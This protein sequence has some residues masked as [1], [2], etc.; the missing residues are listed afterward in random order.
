MPMICANCG[1]KTIFTQVIYGYERYSETQIL[2]ENGDV[3]DYQ[4]RDNYGGEVT[5]KDKIKCRD[6]DSEDIE[7]FETEGERIKFE[8]EHWRK[9]GTWSVDDL[10][11]EEQDPEFLTNEI[12]KLV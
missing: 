1:N 12:A 6:C 8:S 5:E 10:D 2:D 3:D 11:E 7:D 4:D 9:D